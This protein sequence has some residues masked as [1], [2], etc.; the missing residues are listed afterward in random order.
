MWIALVVG[1]RFAPRVF[2]RLLWFP[3]LH[4]NQHFQIPI[5][6]RLQW[7]PAKGNVAASSL[8]IVIYLFQTQCQLTH[9]LYWLRR[10][11]KCSIQ[12]P[13]DLSVAG[14][15][16][17]QMLGIWPLNS[18]RA[19]SSSSLLIPTSP[20]RAWG[21]TIIKQGYYV[22]VSVLTNKPSRQMVVFRH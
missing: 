1:S 4:K 8:K 20:A 9:L 6:P 5:R 22:L 19:T 16:L 7:K 12:L 11:R 10:L 13:S 21:G 14:A 3:S 18:A 17:R 15:S 2:L